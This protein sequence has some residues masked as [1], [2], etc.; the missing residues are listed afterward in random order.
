M[1]YYNRPVLVRK[2]LES[3]LA[4]GARYKNWELAFGDDGSDIPGEPIVREIMDGHLN[5]VT[6]HN[7]H[8]TIEEKAEKGITIGSLANKVLATTDAEI[9]LT[10]CDDDRLHPDYLVGLNRYFLKHPSVMWCYSNVRM[11]NPLMEEPDDTIPLAGP[12]NAHTG[13]LDAYGKVDASQV[14]YCI[15]CFR[16]DVWWRGTTKSGSTNH[17]WRYNLDGELFKILYKKFGPAEYT[18]LVAQYKG[19]HEHQLVY[20][21]EH[22]FRSKEDILAYHKRVLELAGKVF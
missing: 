16:D 8:M 10:L 14:A 15:E 21:K 1:P 18:G 4:A 19:M 5:K 3:V 13:P 11:F 7:S 12:Y 2:A 17:P 9:I 22:I 20:Y 6:F